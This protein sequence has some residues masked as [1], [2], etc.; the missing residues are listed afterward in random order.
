MAT[1]EE[2]ITNFFSD[3]PF[4]VYSS[5]LPSGYQ[6]LLL[7]AC[8]QYLDLACQSNLY[9]STYKCKTKRMFIFVTGFNKDGERWSKVENP[10]DYF[11]KPTIMLAKYLEMKAKKAPKRR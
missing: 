8:C 1:I 4:D 10:N 7:H 11:G 5:F 2:E 6:R 9:N 3:K